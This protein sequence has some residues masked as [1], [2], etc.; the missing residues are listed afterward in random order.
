MESKILHET[1]E[2][3]VEA[4]DGTLDGEV[5]FYRDKATLTRD[6]TLSVPTNQQKYVFR[7]DQNDSI[8]A[9]MDDIESFLVGPIFHLPDDTQKDDPMQ[10]MIEEHE[11][12]LL[13]TLID[14][15]DEDHYLHYV[16]DHIE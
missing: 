4:K 16:L 2:G 15:S 8:S 14:E 12:V 5:V 6:N 9:E 1:T 7:K 11:V 13:V 3:P 10:R